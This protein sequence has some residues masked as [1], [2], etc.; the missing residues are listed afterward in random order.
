MLCRHPFI[1]GGMPFPCNQ[2]MP[3]RLQK[4]R[5]WTHRI[6]LEA[7]QWKHNAFVT[8]TYDEEKMPRL[9]D[10]RGTLVPTDVQLWLKKLR[11]QYEP[12]KFRFFC[13]GEYGSKTE[14]PH[15]HLILFNYPECWRL[16]GSHFSPVTGKC[17]SSCDLILDTWGLGHVHV[18]RV[19]IKS[20]AYVSNYTTKKMTRADDLRLNGRAP[21]FARMSLRPGLGHDAMHEVASS[22]LAIDIDK[23]VD[24]PKTLRHGKKEWPLDTYLRRKLRKLIG[25]DERAPDEVLE[26][27]LEELLPVQEAAQEMASSQFPHDIKAYGRIYKAMLVSKGDAKVASME[28]REKIYGKRERL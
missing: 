3:C 20:A 4:K 23:L 10:G 2:C 24:V 22:L 15:Y 16:G 5:H 17:C 13:V 27:L 6:I 7:S 14:R 9:A 18:G 8:L 1:K 26:A 12:L 19:S 21:E 11:R 25:R 28:A